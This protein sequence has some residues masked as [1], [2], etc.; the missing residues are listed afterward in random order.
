MR[1]F[2]SKPISKSDIIEEMRKISKQDRD[3]KIGKM[4]GH[5][6]NLGLSD[7][8]LELAIL[9]YCEF[10][11]K[12][13]LDFTVYPS[14]LKME[15]DIIA[16]S[17]SILN[18][19]EKTVGNFTYG[20]TES[21]ILATK[22]ARDFFIK[23]NGN[24][25]PEILIPLTAHPA[26]Y[27]AS[28]Y[29]Q[30]KAVSVKVDEASMIVDVEDLKEKISNRTAIIV[31]SAPNYPFGTV[32]DI[33]ALSE[34]AL[35]KKVWLHVDACI[36]GFLLPFLRDLGEQISPFDF[37]LEGVSSIS[38]DLH[39]YGYA[40]RG[41]S[42]VLFR[43]SELREGSIFAMS[44]WPGYPIVNTSILSTRSAGPLAAAW[45]IILALG[46]EGYR[47]L[48]ERILKV[49]R[50]L[51][52]GLTKIGYR[53]IGKPLGGIVAFTSD[54][55]DIAELPTELLDWFIQY[56]PGSKELGFPK[57]IHLTITPGHDKVVDSFLK[58]LELATEKIKKK[59]KKA[60]PRFESIEDLSSVVKIL[61]IEEG[62][63]PSDFTTINE[64]MYEMPPE[65]VEYVL[66]FVANEYL[67]RPSKY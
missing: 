57:S 24:E 21:I 8:V 17:A 7:E 56:Q 37:S 15:N 65:L 42:V 10:L 62:K 35:D 12:T 18:G 9:L 29:L 52:Q 61:G 2:P 11:N 64:L 20:G 46:R 51:I 13:M 41:A 34:I 58:D 5:I 22:S 40:P 63:L 59:P 28:E 48:A 6:Y 33:R 32:D 49:R 26:F 27:K 30:L 1:D 4:W 39:K 44:R 47:N 55:F 66:K 25:I 31:G 43:S 38:A 45:T 19:N 14:V 36:G 54:E 23:K 53:I 60:L 3:P 67:F 16:M 50:K